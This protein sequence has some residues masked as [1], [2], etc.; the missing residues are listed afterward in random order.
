ML[1]LEHFRSQVIKA[2]YGR[3]KPFQDRPVTDQQV[4]LDFALSS[5]GPR[6][7][8]TQGADVP[9]FGWWPVFFTLLLRYRD[10]F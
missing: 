7:P 5:P 9:A 6:G 10:W 8:Q 2:T 3:A 4:R 1:Q